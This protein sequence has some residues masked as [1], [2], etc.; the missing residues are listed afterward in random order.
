MGTANASRYASPKK[1]L[2]PYPH[3]Q[4][5]P[6]KGQMHRPMMP[7][8]IY[9]PVNGYPPMQAYPYMQNF[10]PMQIPMPMAHQQMHHPTPLVAKAGSHHSG[11]G[12]TSTGYVTTL[13]SS[14]GG[15][16][17]AAAFNDSKASDEDLADGSSQKEGDQNAEFQPVPETELL[18]D[19]EAV[20]ED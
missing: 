13:P 15:A 2:P 14:S 19:N 3:P 8:Q 11:S 5:M 12:S 7:Q 4:F 6:M 9:I 16:E 18:G 10:Y 17:R 20:Q 1:S